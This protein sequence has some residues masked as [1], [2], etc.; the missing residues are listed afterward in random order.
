MQ[1]VVEIELDEMSDV[2]QEKEI[3]CIR[4]EVSVNSII[5]G[6]DGG[7]ERNALLSV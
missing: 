2:R 5:L 1:V 3:C 6:G 4:T 7:E